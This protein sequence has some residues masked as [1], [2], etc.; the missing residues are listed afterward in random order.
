MDVERRVKLHEYWLKPEDI[1]ALPD[2]WIEAGV[3][4]YY[5][6]THDMAKSGIHCNITANIRAYANTSAPI[7]YAAENRKRELKPIISD[8]IKQPLYGS[9]VTSIR[10]FRPEVNHKRYAFKIRL[11]G[12]HYCPETVW[13]DLLCYDYYKAS[14]LINLTMTPRNPDL[15]TADMILDMIPFQKLQ[16]AH[17]R[18]MLTELG[19]FRSSNA[20]AKAARRRKSSVIVDN[21]VDLTQILKQRNKKPKIDPVFMAELKRIVAG[22]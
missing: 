8:T 11:H 3:L 16:E 5:Q 12:F 7:I 20:K 4:D 15:K 14:F 10:F 21:L 17:N 1:L 13:Q 19:D 2:I 9:G 22:E 18:R 6:S